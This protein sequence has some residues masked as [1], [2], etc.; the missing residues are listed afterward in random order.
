[1]Y[2]HTHAHACTLTFTHAQ[3]HSCTHTLTEAEEIEY[4]V[5]I[6]KDGSG[7]QERLSVR[8]HAVPHVR[9]KTIDK[10][11]YLLTAISLIIEFILGF[12]CMCF[13]KI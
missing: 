6:L 13:Y 10:V 3:A 4:P 2:I 11:F 9:K 12:F 7:A 5:R 1:M 8:S